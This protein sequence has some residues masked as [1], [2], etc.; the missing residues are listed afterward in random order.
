MILGGLRQGD[1]WCLIWGSI[2]PTPLTLLVVLQRLTT[3]ETGTEN[4]QE[5]VDIDTK[6]Q[7]VYS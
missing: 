7:G 4:R 6:S 3:E 1:S 5:G 2:L